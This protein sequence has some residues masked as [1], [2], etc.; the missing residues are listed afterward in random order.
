[1]QDQKVLDNNSILIGIQ[2]RRF[3]FR[4]NTG[5][6]ESIEHEY[7]EGNIVLYMLKSVDLVV[8]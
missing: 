8:R 4:G 2:W 7:T 6:R 3:M 5:M 1:M